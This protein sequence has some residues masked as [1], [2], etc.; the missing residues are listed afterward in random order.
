M[1]FSFLRSL[2]V[3]LVPAALLI[4]TAGCFGGGSSTQPGDDGG[5][6]ESSTNQQGALSAAASSQDFGTV[7]V[8]AQSAAFGVV[9]KNT[10]AD[11]IEQVSTALAGADADSFGIDSDGCSGKPL[12]GGASCTVQVHFA[13]KSGG[14][15]SANLTA[16]APGTSASVALAGTAAAASGSLAVAPT[17]KDF[18]DVGTGTTSPATSFTLTNSGA[19][20]TGNV[21]VAVTGTDKASFT[22]SDP[23]SGKPLAAG[24]SCAVSVSFAPAAAGTKAASLAATADGVTGSTTASLAGTGVAPAAFSVTPATY[25]FGSITEGTTSAA[26]TLTVQ[27]TGGASGTPA[28]AV[29]GANAADFTLASNGC[30]GSLAAGAKCTVGVTFK[31][32]TAS[33]ETA[34]VT[35]GASGAGQGKATLTGTGLAAAALAIT[36][37]T[38]TFPGQEVGTA[39]GDVAFTVKNGGGVTTGTLQATLGGTNASAF[40]LPTAN[41][42]CSGK[43]LAAGATC[44]VNVH[45]APAAN[46]TPGNLQATLQVAGTPGGTAS[47]TLAGAAL[48][49]ATLTMT[50]ATQPFGT[51]VLGQKSTDSPFTVTNTGGVASGALTATLGGTDGAQ[52]ALGTDGCTGKTLDAGKS[53]TVNVHFAPAATAAV[54]LKQ[55]TLTVAGKPGGSPAST[56][57]GTA[58]TQAALGITPATV[59]FGTI[60][61]G[62]K[63]ADTTLTVKNGGGVPT[64]TLAVTLGGANGGQFGLGTDGCTGKV[65]DAGASCTVGVHFS[66][67]KTTAGLQTATLSVAGT[68]GGSAPATL[69][70]TSGTPAALVIQ[71]PASFGGFKAEIGTTQSVAFSLANQGTIVSGTPTFTAGGD[72]AVPAATNACTTGVG[73]T[74]CDFVVT[75][76]PKSASSTATLTAAANPGGPATY[77]LSGAG[78]Q[79]LI[80]IDATSWAPST[81]KGVP[82]SK[83]FT[84]KNNGTAATASLQVALAAATD[85]SMTNGC[86]M[87][88]NPS[89][90]CQITLTFAATALEAVASKLTVT[91]TATDQVSASVKGGAGLVIEPD[92][93]DFG[94]VNVAGPYPAN[95]TVTMTNYGSSPAALGFMSYSSATEPWFAPTD[96]CAKQTLATGKSCAITFGCHPATAATSATLVVRAM[97]PNEAFISNTLNVSC[98][99]P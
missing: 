11:S 83:V 75:Y 40:V 79:P 59:P 31:P 87:V 58:A 20:A 34:S 39:G 33:A 76:T 46:A 7:N 41:D 80:A 90:T 55:G 4:P 57:T 12:A 3:G 43:T 74:P 38:E 88:L 93:F 49:P 9:F 95:Q 84:I 61:Q 36:P 97:N 54:G 32:S 78:T 27:N 60:L 51:I 25:D 65:L 21:T 71:P 67:S 19:G 62:T 48:A 6:P 69:T 92:V 94:S 42:G 47:S 35:A 10:G 23:C 15:K 86:S 72:F 66:P 63:T 68:P 1:T 89:S 29:A 37:A 73:A 30:T 22:V 26:Q 99:S 56:L 24:A 85:L 2:A 53:C 98:A 70:G 50:P 16:S 96:T 91:D 52:Y 8:G 44:T 17:T 77:A 5:T 28:V 18:G 81:D 45:F 14:A 13:P 82:V 64:G